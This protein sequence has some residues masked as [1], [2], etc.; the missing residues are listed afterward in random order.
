MDKKHL[1]FRIFT[2]S[3]T[4]SIIIYLKRPLAQDFHK[5]FVRH[6]SNSTILLWHWPYGKPYHLNGDLCL[7]HYGIHGCLLTDNRAF[8]PQAD[9]VVFHHHELQ[10][11]QQML[12]LH[13]ARPRCQKWVWLSLENPDNSG[14]QGRPGRHHF[15]FVMTYRQDADITIPYGKLVPRKTKN[16]STTDN[17]VPKNKTSLA[18]WVVSNY[19]KQHKR[20]VVYEKLK[21]IIHVDVHGAAANKLLDRD[22]LLPAI[23]RCYF[24]LSFENSISTDYIT[25]KFW[26]NGLMGGSVPVV[27]GP[28]RDQYENVAPGDSFI[29]VDDFRSVEELGEFLKKLADNKE[30][31]SKYFAW[32]KQYSVKLYRD[33]RERLCAICPKLNSL[34]SK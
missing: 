28:P 13:L 5:T 31:Y 30:E 34:H 10:S 15:N 2:T 29:H 12:P 19:Q 21:N 32:K 20:T 4:L 6:R 1:L 8:F 22:R 11:G 17:F 18:C 26:Y 24:Y 14:I 25:E 23:S 16:S 27:L 3:V 7:K 33:W 9:L